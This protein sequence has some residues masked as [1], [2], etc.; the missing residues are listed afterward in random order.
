VGRDGLLVLGFDRRDGRT[1]LTE[2]RYALPLQALEVMALEADAASLLLLNPTGGLLGGDRLETRLRL[3]EGAHVCLSTPSATRVYR[4]TGP[5]A[6]Q[7]LTATLGPGARLEYM[8]DHLIPSP[9]ARLLQRTE[10]RLG[11]DAT[12]LVWDA[13]AVGRPARAETWSFAEL[14][15]TLRI[16]DA[17]GPLLH[18]RARLE[19]RPFWA[20]L[21]GAEGMAYVGT[22]AMAGDPAAD[23]VSLARALTSGLGDAA[24]DAR[25]GVTALSRGGALARVLAPSAPALTRLAEALWVRARRLLFDRPPLGLRKL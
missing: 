21:G 7:R 25:L 12:A 20:G 2:R 8:P 4:S 3:G 13:W 17:G 22:F 23:W 24:G 16:D 6:E 9:G 18:E 15:I 1:V 11:R 10:I 5:V 14:D 19:G